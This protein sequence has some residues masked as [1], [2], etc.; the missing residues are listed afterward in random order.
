M[1]K[2]FLK[3]DQVVLLN[4]GYVS[5]TEGKPVSNQGF[6]NAQKHA[7]YVVTFDSLAK[8]KDFK[9]KRA[10]SL[11]DLQE[12]VRKALEAKAT[13]FVTKPTAVTQALTEQLKAEAMNFMEFTQN[14]SKIDKVNSFLQQF[15]VINE[16][17]QFGL[18]FEDEIVKL[19]KIYTM[20]EVIA[21]VTEVIDL[22]K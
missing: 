21:S 12:K 6:Y 20:E 10:D 14:S 9:G 22:L 18:F 17:E 16:F 13:V 2:Q 8:G 1:G 4:G 5:T 15:E 11:S 3:K 7:E 19:N